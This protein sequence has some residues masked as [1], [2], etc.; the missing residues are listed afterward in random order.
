[1]T[2][3]QQSLYTI[4]TAT[5]HNKAKVAPTNRAYTRIMV[6][7]DGH[8]ESHCVIPAAATIAR[9]HNAEL[10]LI[11]CKGMSE[12]EMQRKCQSL[13]YDRINVRGYTISNPLHNVPAWVIAS[14]QADL[15]VIAQQS[16]DWLGRLFTG[17]TASQ[18]HNASNADVMTVGA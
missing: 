4:E 17:D 6:L 15:I 1:M 13:T 10:I 11:G 18:L 9:Q 16:K 14:E 5:S 7:V 3:F 8:P 2:I 12:N